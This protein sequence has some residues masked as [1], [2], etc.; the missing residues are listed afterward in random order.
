MRL[1]ASLA[2]PGAQGGKTQTAG[3]AQLG[4]SGIALSPRGLPTCSLQRGDRRHHV[5]YGSLGTRPETVRGPRRCLYSLA[6][7][8]TECDLHH[9]LLA[10]DMRKV[11]LFQEEGI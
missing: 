1:S 4:P 5:G 6:S 11:H 8:V 3:A 10:Q 2:L 9:T 7:E